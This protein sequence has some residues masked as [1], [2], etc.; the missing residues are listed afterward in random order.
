MKKKLLWL[1]YCLISLALH[2]KTCF[3]AQYFGRFS[4]GS[5]SSTE[6]LS[7]KEMN[8]NKND[9]LNYS[10]RF[11]LRVT[12]IG[13]DDWEFVTD[14]RD[15]FDQF[16]S[17]NKTK[18]QLDPQNNYQTRQLFISNFESSKT[19][20]LIFGRFSL[21]ESGGTFT[22][23]IATQYHIHNNY[24]A[25][26][27]GGLNPLDQGQTVVTLNERARNFGIYSHYEQNSMTYPESLSLNH[28]Y[29]SQQYDADEDRRYFFQS[30]YY[31]WN[32]MSRITSNLYVDFIPR[33]F[34]QNGSLNWDQSWSPL[35][36]SHFNFLTVDTIQ[37]RR[38]QG[39]R[40]FLDPS[41]Y[42][43]LKFQFDYSPLKR[44]IFS[45]SYTEGK[46]S[47]DGLSKKKL[48]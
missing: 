25:G 38:D 37:Y 34:I 41:P 40:E 32:F 28:S 8:S 42:Q 35:Y 30:I 2:V 12:E 10:G 23:G 21:L 5:F 31:Q 16:D 20:N 4:L 13:P 44:V 3:G 22:D 11:Y 27:F 15:K 7:S 14:L 24:R 26:F 48:V 6:R 19:F 29:V 36:S 9:Q 33:T 47:L 17:L 39:I 45:P 43:Q 1:I 46:R 18:L